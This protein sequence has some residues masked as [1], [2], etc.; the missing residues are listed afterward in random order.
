M[1]QA[2]QHITVMWCVLVIY[3]VIITVMT[4]NLQ[5]WKHDKLYLTQQAVSFIIVICILFYDVFNK[6]NVS[7][8]NDTR[9]TY[10]LFIIYIL[11]F[12][13]YLSRLIV[14]VTGLWSKSVDLSRWDSFMT[15]FVIIAT[16]AMIYKSMKMQFTTRSSKM[17]NMLIV[18]LVMAFVFGPSLFLLQ[19][20]NQRGNPNKTL[21][22][23][24]LE[25]STWIYGSNVQ[26]LEAYLKGSQWVNISNG[27][28]KVDLDKRF[29]V[30]YNTDEATLYVAFPGTYSK[31]QA[32]TNVE[33][34][35]KTLSVNDYLHN[36]KDLLTDIA[37]AQVSRIHEGFYNAFMRLSKQLEETI[38]DATQKHDIKKIVVCGHSLGG[39]LATLAV[40]FLKTYDKLSAIPID[41]YTFGSPA[42]GDKAFADIFNKLVNEYNRI[43]N[44]FDPIVFGTKLQFRHVKGN[45][46]VAMFGLQNFPGIAHN[47]GVYRKC[48]NTSRAEQIASIYAP[49]FFGGLVIGGI[50]FVSA[51]FLGD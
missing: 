2:T 28:E 11:A 50:A 18:I 46:V 42:V 43:T 47:T 21:L 24:T 8:M 44:P 15:S 31:E 32:K 13:I 6:G 25:L 35:N 17:V 39:A 36:K 41:C 33:I 49:V 23:N 9:G 7:Y 40:P 27:N 19:D 34:G 29:G 1:N 5:Q 22:M 16:C 45:Y 26:G 14:G 20:F 37:K 12:A 51:R 48:L 38:V 30:I 4:M 3:M 10:V